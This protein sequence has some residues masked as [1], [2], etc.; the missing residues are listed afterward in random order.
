MQDQLHCLADAAPYIVAWPAGYYLDSSA[1]YS[2]WN[3]PGATVRGDT[4]EEGAPCM[5]NLYI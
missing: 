4:L 1:G 5:V 3:V 2:S